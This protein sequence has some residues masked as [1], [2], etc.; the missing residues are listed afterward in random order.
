MKPTRYVICRTDAS[1]SQGWFWAGAGCWTNAA[2]AARTFE[3][4]TD[5]ELVGIA[6]CP[7]PLELWDVVTVEPSVDRGFAA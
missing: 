3:F 7:L 2:S 6:E 1:P 4:M 5:A